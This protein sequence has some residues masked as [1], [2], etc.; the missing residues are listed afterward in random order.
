MERTDSEDSSSMLYKVMV[1][2]K[3]VDKVQMNMNSNPAAPTVSVGEASCL[4]ESSISCHHADE[5]EQLAKDNKSLEKKYNETFEALDK[6]RQTALD[7]S[8]R[9][10]SREFRIAFLEKALHGCEVSLSEAK[11]QLKERDKDIKQMKRDMS[12]ELA[13]LQSQVERLNAL[14]AEKDARILELV[15]DLSRCR[16]EVSELTQRKSDLLK[17]LKDMCDKLNTVVWETNQREKMLNNLESEL[18]KREMERQSAFLSEVTRSKRLLVGIKVK[19]NMLNQLISAK[20]QKIS[21]LEQQIKQLIS[22]ISRINGV[23]NDINFGTDA[24]ATSTTAAITNEPGNVE[25]SLTSP[26]NV[27]LLKG[28]AKVIL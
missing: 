16:K 5:L 3:I 17:Q 23:F 18:K 15:N 14:V 20:N 21:S 26:C 19:E 10:L 9:A 25:C 13:V 24:A 12:K 2:R 4:N 8:E 28:R 22:K 6:V 1:N 27:E 7:A 11:D